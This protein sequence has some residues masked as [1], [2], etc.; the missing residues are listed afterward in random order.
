MGAQR[1]PGLYWVRL[2]FVRLSAVLRIRFAR[3]RG[4][5]IDVPSMD[6][7]LERAQWGPV[8]CVILQTFVEI[9]L[10]SSR[11]HGNERDATRIHQGT[12]SADAGGVAD[13]HFH[14]GTRQPTG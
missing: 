9:G 7:F 2:L 8:S 12:T 14:R 3:Y 10:N 13:R 5:S 6:I 4:F 11:L 1:R